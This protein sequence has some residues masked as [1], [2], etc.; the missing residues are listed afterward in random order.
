VEFDVEKDE[1]GKFK[2]TNVTLPGGQPVKPPPKREPRA[3]S[4]DQENGD[5]AAAAPSGGRGGGRRRISGRS[6]PGGRGRGGSGTSGPR[7]PPKEAF[8]SVM[9]DAAKETVKSKGIDLG[10]KLTIDLA[11][12]DSRV[13]LGQGGYCSYCTKDA[14]VYE[15]TF[16]C[17]ENGA[18]QFEWA[19][20]LV[21]T[22]GTWSPTDAST[23]MKSLSLTG[24]T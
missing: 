2:A 16:T 7:P 22:G 6:G 5:G 15:G 21:C 19:R 24:G 14:K 4:A 17:D 8:H 3:P 13:K 9:T 20:A 12:G 11:L 18:I 23:G 10:T 1:A